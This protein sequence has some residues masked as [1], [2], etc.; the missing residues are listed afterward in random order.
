MKLLD[1][2]EHINHMACVSN[3]ENSLC[4]IFTRPGLCHIADNILLYLD[5]LSLNTCRFVSQTWNNNIRKF[6][7]IKFLSQEDIVKERC[8]KLG[9]EVSNDR[10]KGGR[11]FIKEYSCVLLPPYYSSHCNQCLVQLVAPVSCRFCTQTRY[12]R[13]GLC[14]AYLAITVPCSGSC[15]DIAWSGH[16]QHECGQLDLL[17]SVGIGKQ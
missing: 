12:C 16:H 5:V 14:P 13:Y 8:Y 2:T 6:I 10:V 7:S 17:H 15:R 1:S 3:E 4:N 9:L 11:G